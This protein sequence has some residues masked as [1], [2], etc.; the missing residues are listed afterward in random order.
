[1]SEPNE[2]PEPPTIERST[3]V[4]LDVDQVWQLISTARGW[5]SWLVDEA[6]VTV[7]PGEEGSALDDGR[8]RTVRVDSI[9]DRRQ[10]SFSWWDRDDPGSASR[11][12]LEIVGLPSG[13]SRLEITERFVGAATGVQAT[14]AE[15]AIR[16]C[17]IGARWEVK[18]LL[19]CV[20]ALPSLVNA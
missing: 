8:Q 11:V 1:M 15:T 19:L 6:D 18:L 7:A 16:T 20:M 14:T 2:S 4:D 10:V 5:A 13:G 9:I 12:Q 3:E 17:S